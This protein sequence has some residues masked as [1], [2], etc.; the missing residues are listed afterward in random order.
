[1]GRIFHLNRLPRAEAQALLDQ[2]IALD[3]R[4]FEHRSE[5]DRERYHAGMRDLSSGDKL[6]V[7]YEEGTELIGYNLIK[8][9]PIEIDGRTVWVVGSSA[10]LLPGHTGG[11]RT[12]LD[13]IRAT[14]RYKLRHPGRE[15]YFVTFIVSPGVYDLFADLSAAVFP[16]V[17]RP[18]PAGIERS[19]IAAAAERWGMP[20]V[21]DEPER[22][23]ASPGRL[24]REPYERRRE[25]E[26]VRF[27]EALNPRH[28]EGELLGVCVPLGYRDLLEGAI[29]QIQ[30]KWRRR[31]R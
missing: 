6:L 22:L 1:M 24:L 25:G 8:L 20:V 14:V 10:G 16:S 11:N 7:L 23:I 18:R 12:I 19:L 4:V 28:A 5:R 27:F 2:V 31:R 9:L 30:R 15:L 3:E 13:A 29:R 21:T 17:R 26:H